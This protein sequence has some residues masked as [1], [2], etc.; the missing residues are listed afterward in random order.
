M[1]DLREQ[2]ARLLRGRVCLV[3]VG[4]AD[5]GDDGFGVWLAEAL[6]KS[7]NRRPKTETNPKTEIRNGVVNDGDS[8]FGSRISDLLRISDFGFAVLLAATA[9]ERHLGRLGAGGFDVVLFLDAVDFG[10]APGAAVLLN[11]REMAACFPQISTHK[12]SLGLLAQ[13]LE[14]GGRTQAWL[15]GVQPETLKP[16]TGL[17]PAVATTAECL[18]ELL[19]GAARDAFAASFEKCSEA[20]SPKSQVRN[21]RR[22]GHCSDFDFQSSFELRTYRMTF[23]AEHAVL[24]AMLICGSGA[25]L[26]L[27]LRR[28]KALAGWAAFICVLAS[29]AL[30]LLE[31]AQVLRSG[32][33]EARTFLAI[34]PLG[35]ALRLYVDG[36]SAVFLCL[37]AVVAIPAS[38][39]SIDYMAH[40][41]E[42]GVGRY[43]PNF[44]LFVV[45]LYGLVSTTDMMWF[46]FIFWQMMTWAGWALIRFERRK[47]ENVRA[48]TKYLW[49]M[50]LACAVTMLGAALLARTGVTAGGETL[51][52]YDFDAVL[53][54]LPGQLRSQAG[55]VA[56]AFALFLV[57]FGIKLGMWPFGQFWL[58]DA[59]PAAP[60]PVSAMLSGVMLKTGV[61]GLM[62]YFIWLV[63]AESRAD[64]PAAKWGL[65]LT[66][67]GT[68]TLFTGTVQALRQE[69]SKRLLAF[70]SIGQGGYI[71]FGLGVCLTL[72]GSPGESG[73]AL[74]AAAF[75]GALFHTLNHGVFKSLLFLNAGSVLLATGTQDLNKL[76]GLMRHLPV[77]AVTALIASFAIA[78]VPL[79]SG[80][81]SKWSIFTAA[82]QGGAVARWLPVCVLVAIF[83]SAITLALFIKFFGTMFLSRASDLVAERARRHP[84][85]EVPVKMRLAQAALAGVC[86]LAGLLPMLALAFINSAL[87]ASRQ[88]LGAVLADTRPVAFS[89]WT[90]LDSLDQQAVYAPLVLL[91]MLVVLSAGVRWFSKLG[92]APRRAA[93]PW[94]CGYAR[95]AEAHRYCAS[96]LYG[97]VRKWFRWLGGGARPGREG[98]K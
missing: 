30:V 26:T 7:E 78:G 63:P 16:G 68:A 59:H 5:G 47:P 87:A 77:T 98:G 90:G 15:L 22:T 27:A 54:H 53:H 82:I 70:S 69:Q 13:L 93:A 40:H 72:L 71:L 24:N 75:V 18:A 4:N 10:G 95:E 62:R 50:Q 11:A 57:G 2:L 49:M 46:F 42:H 94:L 65:V 85:L 74:A 41:P 9:P 52:K 92:G 97:E 81:A 66:L 84:Q 91:A 1:P 3:G 79:F 76:G 44:L 17:S 20:R 34:A 64:Y 25:L 38:F 73:V 14:A 37:I 51:M 35:F 96:G 33:G 48:A 28:R 43:Y 58:P 12:L 56:L 67:L 55:W 39:Y 60:S 31:S 61:Y 29:S 6:V 80:F 86:V 19:A 21:Q 45:A 32:A 23:T 83:T 89:A 36:L 8:D 88:G